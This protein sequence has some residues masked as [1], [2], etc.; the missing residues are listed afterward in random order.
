M[1]PKAYTN[2][3]LCKNRHEGSILGG[4]MNGRKTRKGRFPQQQCQC[5]DNN[6]FL[7]IYNLATEQESENGPFI[8]ANSRASVEWVSLWCNESLIPHIKQLIKNQP[9]ETRVTSSRETL[10]TEMRFT[11]VEK[12]SRWKGSSG[13]WCVI[14]WVQYM[15]K[16]YRDALNP[17]VQLLPPPDMQ[18]MLAQLWLDLIKSTRTTVFQELVLC[19]FGG[20]NKMK[21]R[22]RQYRHLQLNRSWYWIELYTY[23]KF[24][25]FEEVVNFILLL[26]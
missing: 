16:G 2:R 17:P 7:F 18:T 12:G 4:W 21:S 24:V 5:F 19:I 8:G 23:N 15:T 26:G 20:N 14:L 1:F 10:F 25:M 22:E 3:L 9:I 11:L 13:C 6:L